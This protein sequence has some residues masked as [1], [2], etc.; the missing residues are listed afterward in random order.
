MELTMTKASKTETTV[1][2]ETTTINEAPSV[3]TQA[4]VIAADGTKNVSVR[5]RE[6]SAL[7]IKNGPITKLLT[8][9]GY[10]TKNGTEIRFQHVRNV[11]NT[12]L[13]KSS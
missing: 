7:G 5:I 8:E 2:N 10:R 6:L 12:Q 1:L 13:K 4:K 11:L 3:E 9:A